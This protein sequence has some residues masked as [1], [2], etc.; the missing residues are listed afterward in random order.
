MSKKLEMELTVGS[1]YK[2]LSLGG[3]DKSLETEGIFEG[4]ISV[5]VDE[6]GVMMKLNKK[7]GEMEGKVR[8]IPL[9]VI[10]AI[11]VLEIKPNEKRDI[12]KERPHYVG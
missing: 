5:G 6:I 7:H 12:D 4:F 3:R 11:D 10:L 2:I 8:I 1:E 9:H